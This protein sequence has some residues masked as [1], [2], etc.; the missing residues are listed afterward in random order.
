MEEQSPAEHSPPSLSMAVEDA[1]LEVAA[2]TATGA[3]REGGEEEGREP[4]VASP[5]QST[6]ARE[7]IESILC[8]PSGVRAQ[9]G[10][11]EEDEENVDMFD[12]G[13][14]FIACSCNS[15]FEYVWFRCS[16]CFDLFDALPPAEPV[17][18]ELTF[19][20]VEALLAEEE[21]KAPSE[22]SANPA[23]VLS[24][25]A[26]LAIWTLIV[27]ECHVSTP[28]IFENVF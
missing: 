22:V 27:M 1:A 9:A 15:S 3:A 23:S 14:V 26:A 16:G 12:D 13:A 21:E 25:S 7:E 4:A 24:F 20:E 2:E 5:Q 19:E 18:N 10:Q 11:F 28:T 8:S 17:L 6:A